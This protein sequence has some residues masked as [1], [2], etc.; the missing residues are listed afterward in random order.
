LLVESR[1]DVE[2]SKT[3]FFLPFLAALKMALTGTF[4]KEPGLKTRRVEEG[5][6]GGTSISLTKPG[7]FFEFDSKVVVFCLFLDSSCEAGMV[8]AWELDEGL[9]FGAGIGCLAFL[10]DFLVS[11]FGGQVLVGTREV[12]VVKVTVVRDI[13]VG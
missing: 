13:S 11:L 4:S 9:S 10:G 2:N 6:S 3:I 1:T 5:V 7:P 8:K 12:L